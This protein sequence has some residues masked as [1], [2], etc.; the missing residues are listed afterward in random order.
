MRKKERKKE[1]KK[2]VRLRKK[3]W[4]FIKKN[5]IYEIE[6]NGKKSKKE[7]VTHKG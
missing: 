4:K 1:R 6:K 5:D 7:K 2:I 3:E